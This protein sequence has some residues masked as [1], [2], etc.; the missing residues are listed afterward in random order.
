MHLYSGNSSSDKFQFM[1]NRQGFDDLC[2]LASIQESSQKGKSKV[3][4]I[5]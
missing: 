1:F 4:C 5:I 3:T 2:F